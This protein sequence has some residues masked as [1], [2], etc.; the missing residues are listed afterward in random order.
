[1][2]GGGFSGGES[3][4]G[5]TFV[6]RIVGLLLQDHAYTDIALH[7]STLCLAPLYYSTYYIQYTSAV[8]LLFFFPINKNLFYMHNFR[9]RY[10]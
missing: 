1:M 6:S 9:D 7:S 3:E 5:I 2:G 4:R 10:M 8:H